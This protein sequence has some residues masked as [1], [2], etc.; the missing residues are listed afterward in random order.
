MGSLIWLRVLYMEFGSGWALDPY[1]LLLW[2]GWALL[3]YREAF[4][5]APLKLISCR[6]LY[7]ELAAESGW[8]LLPYTLLGSGWPLVP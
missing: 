3:P 8:L 1:T 4:S 2:S 5:C 7:I 6:V